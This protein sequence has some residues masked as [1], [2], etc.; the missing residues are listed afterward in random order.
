MEIFDACM[1]EYVYRLVA[2]VK[3]CRMKA[4]GRRARILLNWIEGIP[5]S[6]LKS[7]S[8]WNRLNS[9]ACIC[10]IIGSPFVTLGVLYILKSWN[11]GEYFMPGISKSFSQFR[12][13]VFKT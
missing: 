9:S 3:S 7:R 4:A 6:G 11:F 5:V 12:D 13:P 2:V 10:G 8:R 1:H